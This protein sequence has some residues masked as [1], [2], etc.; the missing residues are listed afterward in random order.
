MD[1]FEICED[2]KQKINCS[3]ANIYIIIKDDEEILWCKDC[4]HDLW[5]EAY[6]NGWRG[7]DIENQLEIDE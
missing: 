1:D 5:E 2:C 7:D 4:F 3:K 6:K